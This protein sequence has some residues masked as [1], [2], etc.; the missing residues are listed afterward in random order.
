MRGDGVSEA[1]VGDVGDQANMSDAHPASRHAGH[2]EG[3]GDPVPLA[4]AAVVGSVTPGAANQAMYPAL[5]PPS[6]GGGGGRAHMQGALLP[7]PAL[8]LAAQRSIDINADLF[9]MK[10]MEITLSP[11]EVERADLRSVIASLFWILG[12]SRFYGR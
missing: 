2:G 10:H 1:S 5:P 6:A 7:P 3:V 12:G 11:E 4:T 9:H 8:P